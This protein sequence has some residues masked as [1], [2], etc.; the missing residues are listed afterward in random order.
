MHTNKKWRGLKA[1]IQATF[2]GQKKENWLKIQKKFKK[3]HNL[4][5]W[6]KLFVETSISQGYNRINKIVCVFRSAI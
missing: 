4:F 1:S 5:A 3:V 6:Q 2:G